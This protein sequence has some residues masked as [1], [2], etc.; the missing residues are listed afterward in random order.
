MGKDYMDQIKTYVEL[1]PKKKLPSG[2]L[3][4]STMKNLEVNFKWFFQT[5]EYDWETINAATARYVDEYER[6][7][8]LYMQTSKYFICK[9]QQDRSKTSE[10]ADYC[11]LVASGGQLDEYTYFKEKVV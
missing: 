7:N 5:Y 6:N 4:R 1:F 8:Y 10:L 2:K 9:T 3:A 11:E